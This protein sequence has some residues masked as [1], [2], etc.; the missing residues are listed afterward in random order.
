[1][2]DKTS[3][4]PVS[5]QRP[6]AAPDQA[7]PLV[8]AEVTAAFDPSTKPEDTSAIQ[9]PASEL[10]AGQAE[11]PVPV[12]HKS[13]AFLQPGTQ[14]GS[15]G[16]LGHFEVLEL[17]GK[18]GF[19][20]VLKA[21]DDK[22]QRLVAIKVLGPQLTGSANARSRFVREARAAAAVNSKYV[23]STYEVYEQ[24]IPYLVME[25]VVGKSLQDRLDRLEP[26]ATR[27]ILRI[28]AEIAKGLAAAH[29]Q[30]LIH[31]DIKPANILLESPNPQPPPRSGE[32]A[33]SASEGQEPSLAL[34]ANQ[35]GKGVG[36]GVG[37]VKIA[38][39]G[40][41]RAVDD[42]GLT[43][44]G[45]IAGTPLFMSPE[46]ARGE[47]LD[48]RS[49]L[50]SLGSVLYTLCTGHPPFKAHT[51]LGVM[52]RVCDDT[53]RPIREIN[54]AIPSSL[55]EIVNRLLVKDP[56]GRF[57]TAA[58]V[59][60]RLEQQLAH[61]EDSAP[62]SPS[63]GLGGGAITDQLPEESPPLE[64]VLPPIKE[65]RR[66]RT[67]RPW[68][69]AACVLLG[70]VGSI[71][72]GVALWN[73]G[74]SDKA[75]EVAPKDA[76]ADNGEL[77]EANAGPRKALEEKL[78]AEP[79][80][81]ALAAELADLLLDTSWT[82]LK[83]IA[84]TS[85][86][87][88]TL[89]L[90]G[91]GS[92]LASGKNPDRDDYSLVAKTDLQRITAIRLEA[93]PDPSLPHGGPGRFPDNGN[94]H[95]H[96]LQV[97]SGRQ[98]CPLTNI[99]VVHD[100]AQQF[101]NVL[102]GKIA[103]IQGWSNHPRVGQANT[104][105]VATRLQRTPDDDLTIELHFSRAQ[106]LRHNLGRFRLSVSGDATAFDREAT[107]FAAMKLTDPWSRLAAA[108]AV[109]GRNAEA[110]HYFSKALERANG[111]EARKPIVAAAAGFHEVLSAIV[112][113][114][115]DDP[116]LQLALARQQAARGKQHLAEKQPA[117][118]QAELEKARDT[119][120]RLPSLGDTWTVLTPVE[121]KTETGARMELQNDGSVFVHQRPPFK[122]DT[123]TLVF[124]SELKGITGLRLEVLAD[125]RLP[126]G[127]PGWGE[128]GNFVLNELTLQAAPAESPDKARAI[129][130]RNA[131]ADFSQMTG[132]NW[133][134]RG[135]VDGN[136]RTGWAILPEVNKDHTAVF[137]MAEKVGDDQPARL[138]VRLNHQYAAQNH[139]LGRFRLS[140]TNDATT[141]LATR[142]RLDLKN[143][144][145]VDVHVALGEA[146]AQH[147][148]TNE[149]VAAFAL[150]LP[151]AA[152][153]AGKARIVAAAG[154]LKGVLEKLAEG[155]V[156]DGPFQAELARHF[157]KQGKAPLAN[158]ART[159]AR[160]LLEA[161][162]AREPENSAG[163][164]E[165]AQLLL[166]QQEHE[167][168]AQWT[169]L[170]PTEMKSKAGATL[171][172]QDDG[173]ILASGVN[174]SG[175]LYVVSAVS[176]LDRIAAVRL[177]ALPDPSLPNK[178]PGRHS[179]GNFHLGAFRLYQPTKGGG[180]TPLRV[181]SAW[182]SFDFKAADADVAGTVDAS[183]KKFWHVWGRV[184]EAHQA[185][186][187][188]K[189]TAAGPD[190]PFVIELHH[191]AFAEGINLGRFRLSVSGDPDISARERHRFAALKITNPW[192]RLAAAYHLL[193]DQQAVDQLLKQHPAAAAAIGDVYV[194]AQDW[195]RATASYRKALTDQPADGALSAKLAMSHNN[196]GVALSRKGQWDEA[197]ACYREAI[198][199]NPKNAV[200]HSNLGGALSRKGQ[201]DEAIPFCRKAIEL[202]PKYARAHFR[203]GQALLGKRRYGEARDASARALELLPQNDPSRAAATRQLQACERLVKIEPR[204][205][206]L[207]KGEDKP[208]DN[209]ERLDFA[210]LAYDHKHFAAAA[211]LWAE[212]LQ[213]DPKLADDRQKQYRCN[214]ACAASLAAAGQARDEPPLD[215]AAKALL[216]RQALDWLRAELA[217]LGQQ[218]QSGGPGA[219]AQALA[220]LAHWQKD[221]D[222]AGIRD[223]AGLAQLPADERKACTQLWAD[224]AA[225]LKKAEE[226][227]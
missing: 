70:V 8:S 149:A 103:A 143:S 150:A 207:L 20:I 44:S 114:Q 123:Y 51:T 102:D 126:Q 99:V 91:D 82:V 201:W 129:A 148:Q 184:G 100:E 32:L 217:V 196:L 26:F 76:R 176:N 199:V 58:E 151:L 160:S 220:I 132:G 134:V 153:R 155:A 72:L 79:E 175:D 42:I 173:S 1:M 93:L 223:A 63:G 77:D 27:D 81:A 54:P 2:G 168:A 124:Q 90:Q 205:P 125:S 170:K 43:Q 178:G 67:L 165:L 50:F 130:L 97:L 119:L 89:T 31:R 211:R 83:P 121:M 216:R 209:A 152:D 139:N 157:A 136:G 15:L 65:V 85:K 28:G 34:R 41:A 174:A 61:L 226:K 115:P 21:F 206:L 57:Q 203:L 222:L 3:V 214:A 101:R 154:P 53:P 17:L 219:A 68:V 10:P 147:G 36:G 6:A 33:R 122:N 198:K 47:T 13:L 189:E 74:P 94:F 19:G 138:T 84:M 227:R 60:Q 113:R 190:R 169:V 106:R 185:I 171:T 172:L 104:A 141:L 117:L 188:V 59:A 29:Q 179:S 208:A 194:A 140:V 142:V 52:K 210:Q 109:N 128:N 187:L 193:G 163:A 195:E 37:R 133:D 202:D 204:L 105:I 192:A 108:Y 167:N 137:E 218:L 145:M 181:E 35:A 159:K 48:P 30:G 164:A 135:A 215:D 110:L 88:A 146:Y 144:E 16:R 158:A 156:D 182:A 66:R 75:N 200:A 111:Y 191:R 166:D 80:N 177:E 92:I 131:S 4:E 25:Y 116:Q 224:V 186:F 64:A 112:Q 62:S 40:L 23:V 86:G 213:A 46:Q 71:F 69:A 221:T 197:L 7:A 212:A 183:L 107:R 5:E 22:L 11:Q 180:R 78:A 56:A 24:P 120:K 95:L 127:G 45:M 38:D 49:D 98:P 39:F 9:A 161:K 73:T 162:L 118:A 87:G 12:R 18:G 14:P 225:L 55:V 96:H